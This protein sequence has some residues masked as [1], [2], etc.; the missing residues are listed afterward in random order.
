MN[1]VL[2]RILPILLVIALSA[3]FRDYQHQEREKNRVVQRENRPDVVSVSADDVKMNA[4]IQTA[5]RTV[6]EMSAAMQNPRP[7]QMFTVKIA[8][9]NGETTEHMWLDNLRYDGRNFSGELMN[10]PYN[11]TGYAKGQTMTVAPNKISD[12]MMKDGKT[13]RGGYTIAVMRERETQQSR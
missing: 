5:R 7:N 4:A 13:S 3:G 9:T 2:R 10:E 8:V 6:G 1:S 11:M 12:W